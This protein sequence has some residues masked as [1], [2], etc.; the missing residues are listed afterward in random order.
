MYAL[1]RR[2][3]ATHVTLIASCVPSLYAQTCFWTDGT[4]STG[5]TPCNSTASATNCCAGGDA[6]TV[7]ISLCLLRRHGSLS[8]PPFRFSYYGHCKHQSHANAPSFRHQAS[9][10][11]P[12]TARPTQAAAPTPAG[13][14]QPASKPVPKVD[15]S[16]PH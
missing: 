10:T 16:F 2:S 5:Y 12:T 11:I 6:C 1:S 3:L 4:T 14:I 9:A 8:N 15:L 13:Q 7:S